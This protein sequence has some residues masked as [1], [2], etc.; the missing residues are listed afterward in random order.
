MAGPTRTAIKEA[1]IGIE[2]EAELPLAKPN[3]AALVPATS[4]DL[5]TV[6]LNNHAAIDV[7]E[8]LAALR[9]KEMAR[10]AEQ[11]FNEAMNA[12][13]GEIQRIVPDKKNTQT[14][15]DYASYAKLNDVLRPIYLKH[16]FSLSFDCGQPAVSG[17]VRAYCFVSHRAG[18]TRKYQSPDM[19]LPTLGPQGKPVMTETHGT[20]AAMSYA[21]RYLL[22]YIFNVAVGADDTDGNLTLGNLADWLTLIKEAKTIGE[23]KEQYGKAVAD[24]LL[25]D[26]APKESGLAVE[27]YKTARKKR[28]AELRKPAE[29]EGPL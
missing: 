9:E 16:G 13:Q 17:T 15:S 7:I 19:P 24:A 3:G 4:M 2:A 23:L 8:R 6:A 14:S 22:R 25:P 29:T 12:A 21:M 5:L 10:G 1:G 18:H 27:A 28:E 26:K 11:Q 20:G